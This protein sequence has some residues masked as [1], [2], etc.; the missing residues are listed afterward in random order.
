M[1]HT[2]TQEKIQA[3]RNLIRSVLNEES[4]HI[5]DGKIRAISTQDLQILFRLYD[6]Q[7]FNGYFAQT[8]A[9]KIKF[10]LSAKLSKV[11]GKT[12]MYR[13]GSQI[14]YE[15]R[16]SSELLFRF[17]GVKRQITVCGIVAED[18]LDSLLLVFEHE[19][20]HLYL[21][22]IKAESSCKKPVFQQLARSVFGHLEFTHALP[23]AQEHAHALYGI[24][25]GTKVKFVFEG[26]WISGILHK[27]N[28]R[29]VVMVPSSIGIYQNKKGERFAKYYVSMQALSIDDTN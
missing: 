29:A 10:S 4:Q 19:L 20:M 6:L 24:V 3:N 22:C 8:I 25:A 7:V 13:F 21:M 27:I 11:A 26:K 15:I 28:K 9:N 23:S 1:L 5:K 16:I 18:A 2:L 14:S 12:I 17:E